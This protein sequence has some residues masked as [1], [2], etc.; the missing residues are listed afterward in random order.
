MGS[1]TLSLITIPIF[2]GAIGYLTNWSGVLMLFYPVRFAG[3][4][5]ARAWPRVNLMPERSSRSLA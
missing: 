2:T 4:P 5:G 1:E 3:L